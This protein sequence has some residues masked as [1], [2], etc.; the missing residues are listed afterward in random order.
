VVEEVE[1]VAELP[2][3]PRMGL[4]MLKPCQ[5]QP[6]MAEAEGDAVVPPPRRQ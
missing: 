2:P 1:V 5:L 6:Q 3:L 4:L